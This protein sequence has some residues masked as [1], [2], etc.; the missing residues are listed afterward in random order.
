[1]LRVQSVMWVF[2]IKAALIFC[3][4][5]GFLGLA[6]KYFQS[7]GLIWLFLSTLY[8]SPLQ[9]LGSDYFSLIENGLLLSAKP[10]GMLASVVIYTAVSVLLRFTYLTVRSRLASKS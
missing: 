5:S 6:E 8:Y 3:A 2:S 9:W 10:G 4:I 1:M 7:L